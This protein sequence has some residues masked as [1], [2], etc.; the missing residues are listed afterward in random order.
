MLPC[1]AQFRRQ[2]HLSLSSSNFFL[3]SLP[4]SFFLFISLLFSFCI[5][6]SISFCVGISLFLSLTRLGVDGH[7]FSCWTWIR[8]FVWGHCDAATEHL[9]CA[10]VVHLESLPVKASLKLYSSLMSRVVFL[11]NFWHN[12]VF[13]AVWVIKRPTPIPPVPPW[14]GRQQN[15]S[16]SAAVGAGPL[17]WQQH[18][19]VPRR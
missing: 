17:L 13:S 2:I 16:K 8:H 11:H 19:L 1:P 9:P 7:L 3:P 5:S 4:P 10:F 18:I 6:F 12:S 14:D 15:E